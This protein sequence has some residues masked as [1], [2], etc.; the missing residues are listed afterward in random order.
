MPPLGDQNWIAREGRVSASEVAALMPEGHPYMDARDIYDRLVGLRRM[1]APSPAMRLGTILEPAILA[2]AADFFDLR[3]RTNSRTLVHPTLP[4]CATPDAYALGRREL[5]EIKYS[6][7]PTAWANLPAHVYWQ[8]QAQ[9]MAAPGYRG[10]WV[11]V[12]AGSLRRWY[13]PRNLT[14]SRRIARAVRALTDAVAGG[15]PPAHVLRDRST[16][17]VWHQDIPRSLAE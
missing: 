10:V 14:A 11:V 6:G 13:V 12:L 15:T 3:V 17:N 9:L 2:A 16:I 1:D 4:L 5:V 8:A 7:N